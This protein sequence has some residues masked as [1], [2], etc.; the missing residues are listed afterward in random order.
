MF[1]RAGFQPV[2]VVTG[3]ETDMRLQPLPSMIA[4]G[5]MAGVILII[6]VLAGSGIVVLLC[7]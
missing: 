3:M 7:R 1:Q 4:A 6:L 2:T 5:V